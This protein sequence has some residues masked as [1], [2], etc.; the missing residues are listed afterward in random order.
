MQPISLLFEIQS[1]LTR[2]YRE[3]IM[4]NVYRSAYVEAVV[5]VA[6]AEGGWR[7]LRHWSP[8][9]L[10]H[11]SGCRLEV[12]QAAAAQ[13]GSERRRKGP[14]TF[15]IKSRTGYSDPQTGE[16][17]DEPGRQAHIYVFA[18]HP[19]PDDTADHRDPSEWEF[20]VIAEHRLPDQKSISLNP[21]RRIVDPCSVQDLTATVDAIRRRPS[22]DPSESG[23][24]RWPTEDFGDGRE[25]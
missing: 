25:P 19:I 18:W 16:W 21:L 8:W 6:L 1:L 17:H 2:P 20:Y 7:R 9:D 3:A 4:S 24:S 12:K 10:E 23:W 15:D 5:T 22:P 13:I 11:T 14:A